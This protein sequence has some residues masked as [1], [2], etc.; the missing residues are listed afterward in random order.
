MEITFQSLRGTDAR[1]MEHALLGTQS[2]EGRIARIVSIEQLQA[3]PFTTTITF[4][5]DDAAGDLDMPLTTR[6]AAFVAQARRILRD[7]GERTNQG[8]W[9][10]RTAADVTAE[11]N[12]LIARANAGELR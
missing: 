9:Q 8:Y 10:A 7:G 3:A 4:E 12:T 5:T 11:Y 1:E 2:P 6:G